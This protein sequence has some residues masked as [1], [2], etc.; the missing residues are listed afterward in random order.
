MQE[1]FNLARDDVW[2]LR[3]TTP[4]VSFLVGWY[5]RKHMASLVVLWRRESED[6]CGLTE[7]V[8][9]V[10]KEKLTIIFVEATRNQ[11]GAATFEEPFD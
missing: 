10:N 4:L 2:R 9:S 6:V 7:N 1:W 5:R 3:K 11:S 8:K